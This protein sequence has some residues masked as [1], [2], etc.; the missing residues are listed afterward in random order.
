MMLDGNPYRRRLSDEEIRAGEHRRMV[1]GIWETVGRMQLDHL[2]DAG[3]SP[4]DRLVDIG[5]GS[6]RAGVH[7]ARFLDPG[8]YYGLDLNPTLLA[9]GRYELDLAGLAGRVAG[10]HLVSDGNFSIGR[11]GI[12]FDVA[13]A[14][15]LFTHL[16][17]HEIA[18]CL[19][20]VS[21]H[22]RLDG[23][24][25]ATVFLCPEDRPRSAPLRHDPGGITTFGD[26]NPYHVR[27]SDLERMIA[28]LPLVIRS[29][30]RWGHPRD[31]RMVRMRRVEAAG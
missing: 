10:D 21:A 30:E 27:S 29:I 1:G 16:P 7:L 13:L 25:F 14:H 26:R 12:R 24:L 28:D 17:D 19:R 22:L 9:A 20:E 4:A 23:N 18:R 15:S 3:M 2:V 6:L 5:C 11:F 31:Q 8:C